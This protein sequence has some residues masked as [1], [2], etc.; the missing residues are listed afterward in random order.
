MTVN[1][2][3]VARNNAGASI[4]GLIDGGSL[5]PNGYIE[6]RTGAKP[7]NPQT[8]ATGTLLATL[9]C[10]NPAFG[11][12][13]NGQSLA[14]PISNDSNVDDTGVA[15]WFRVY[16]RDGT[17]VFDGDVTATGGGGDI[18]FDNIN[19]VVGGTAVILSLTAI[20]PQ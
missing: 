9:P 6:I 14:N 10:S 19:F 12:F 1:I 4:T 16:D 11:S 2:S 17:A 5:N 3:T 7:A 18:E 20:M 13:S 15:G 8:A